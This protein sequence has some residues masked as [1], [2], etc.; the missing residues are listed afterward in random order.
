MYRHRKLKSE[1]EIIREFIANAMI[2]QP[3]HLHVDQVYKVN[4]KNWLAKSFRLYEAA[5]RLKKEFLCDYKIGL[6]IPLAETRKNNPA[7]VN[8]LNALRLQKWT[9]PQ[10][11]LYRM[12]DEDTLVH[13]RKTKHKVFQKQ[14]G[15]NLFNLYT[16]YRDDEKLF[17]HCLYL[18]E[19]FT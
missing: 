2:Y 13:F 14:P 19:D 11:G 7:K 17:N 8:H 10:I 6:V 4:R 1:D 5:I 12:A 3:E 15:Y 16:W 18:I 9:P